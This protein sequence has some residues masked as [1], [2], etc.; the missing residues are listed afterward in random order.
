[1]KNGSLLWLRNLQG[2]SGTLCYQII[3]HN[4]GRTVGLLIK[5]LCTAVK[6]RRRK[7][8]SSQFADFIAAANLL[9]CDNDSPKTIFQ[10][11]CPNSR[12]PWRQNKI[13][14]H[15]VLTTMT[16]ILS[17]RRTDDSPAT[18]WQGLHHSWWL[19]TNWATAAG[20]LPHNWNDDVQ[21]QGSWRDFQTNCVVWVL[22]TVEPG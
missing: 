21:L 4:E 2:Q 9:R 20:P 10:T 12:G 11:A 1:M 14:V 22:V 7:E 15:Y 6:S 18:C 17:Q 16:P 13:L 8:N 19:P 3:C 5:D